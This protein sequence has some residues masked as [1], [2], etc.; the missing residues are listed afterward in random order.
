MTESDKLSVIVL[1]HNN[2]PMTRNCLET[3]SKAVTGLDHEVLLLDNASTDDTGP[4]HECGGWFQRF[5]ICRNEDNSP[6]ASANNRAVRETSGQWLLF[7]NNDVTV[8]RDSVERL[9]APL[10]EDQGIGITGAK[11]LFPGEAAVQHAGIGQ[12]LWGYPSN[13]GVGASPVDAR[14][15]QR[16]ERFALTGAML[17]LRRSVFET[18]GGFD[19][20]YVWGVEDVDLCLK[21]RAAGLKPVYQPEA[22]SVHVES[23]TLKVTRTWDLDHNY[24]LYRNLWDRELRAREQGYVRRLEREGIRRVAVFGT[25]VAARGLAR[26]LDDSGIRIVTFTSSQTAGTGEIFLDRPV[27]PLVSLKR[28][29]YDRLIVA[30]QYFFEVEPILRA[31][32]PVGEPIFPVLM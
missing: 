15:N 26:V 23:A 28:V 1:M 24:R 27:L 29:A 3:L 13:Y 7:L 21:I 5:K 6:F 11:L 25:G 4:L 32:D 10:R 8:G 16:C 12:M 9:L 30:T 19:E 17:C 22:V 31:L 20:R 14:V 2:V 18:V